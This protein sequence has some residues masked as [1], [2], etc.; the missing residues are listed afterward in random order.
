[1]LIKI[2]LMKQYEEFS[3]IKN[4]LQKALSTTDTVDLTADE[5]L[6]I[7]RLYNKLEQ[8]FQTFSSNFERV[9]EVSADSDTENF[10][11]DLRNFHGTMNARPDHLTLSSN[12]IESFA[13]PIH[14]DQYY[15]IRNNF[16]RI[17]PQNAV[18]QNTTTDHSTN[19]PSETKDTI[20][21]DLI[22]ETDYSEYHKNKPKS[23]NKHLTK[24]QSYWEKDTL[25][26][27]Y[28]DYTNYSRSTKQGHRSEILPK[29]IT[30]LTH[31][32]SHGFVLFDISVPQTANFSETNHRDFTWSNPF[33]RITFMDS[34]SLADQSNKK[35][36]ST[37]VRISNGKT[38]DVLYH[39]LSS[40]E[41]NDFSY[42]TPY[43]GTIL[44]YKPL[45]NELRQ[46][47]SKDNSIIIALTKHLEQ[48]KEVINL[49]N[50][51]IEKKKQK[52]VMQLN[53]SIIRDCHPIVIKQRKPKNNKPDPTFELLLRVENQRLF[54][55]KNICREG[56]FIDLKLTFTTIKLDV[57][58]TE[59]QFTAMNFD[60][61]P[62]LEHVSRFIVLWRN[63][64]IYYFHI[65]RVHYSIDQA[66]LQNLKPLP[67]EEELR[68]SGV[69]LPDKLKTLPHHP[70]I[71]NEFRFET[72]ISDQLGVEKS[73]VGSF[74]EVFYNRSLN[75]IGVAGIFL[76][77]DSIPSKSFKDLLNSSTISE[78][79]VKLIFQNFAFEDIKSAKLELP[80]SKTISKNI[81][82]ADEE[83]LKKYFFCSK[84]QIE[85]GTT[86]HKPELQFAENTFSYNNKDYYMIVYG[87]T[88]SNFLACCIIR[89]G[90]L[91][92]ELV[93][94][95]TL[96]N[97]EAFSAID[98]NRY[99]RDVKKTNSDLIFADS[100]LQKKAIITSIGRNLD[101]EVQT[102]SPK[103]S[104]FIAAEYSSS[105]QLDLDVKK[106]LE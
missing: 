53:W 43:N 101:I 103:A 55:T 74:T 45:V 46:T 20:D 92:E 62:E 97:L 48:E 2:R 77:E 32:N 17:Y 99:P 60:S 64:T 52:S 24:D 3:R 85:S 36:I 9:L 106:F 35:S 73:V 65:F 102:N 26:N 21:F 100:R 42:T 70:S 13:Q 49:M 4:V 56:W 61:G 96:I 81:K 31:K 8:S 1:M 93:I 79:Y 66:N 54:Y 82:Q 88:R 41:K 39:S 105:V 6:P 90:K 11:E 34:F 10:L 83:G 104:I 14:V 95:N 89:K 44:F 87:V 57:P 18:M 25:A 37:Y 58:A 94:K 19:K 98:S 76:P 68:N 71:T 5:S 33:N 86:G 80:F 7:F 59:R 30:L 16:Q 63:S 22:T 67:S 28:N 47:E 84:I 23:S 15:K 51:S 69:Q 12:T 72:E 50:I 78:A 40:T 38:G 75:F 27:T 29:K 91:K